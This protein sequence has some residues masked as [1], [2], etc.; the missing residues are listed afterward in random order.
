MLEDLVHAGPKTS[1]AAGRF[2]KI[3]GKT[4]GEAAA[5]LMVLVMEFASEPA[6]K[7]LL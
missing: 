5:Q 7:A 4:G 3:L 6:R 1:Q 2:R